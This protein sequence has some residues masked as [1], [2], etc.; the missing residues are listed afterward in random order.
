MNKYYQKCTEKFQRIYS[1]VAHII[2]ISSI[3]Y[4]FHF[5]RNNFFRNSILRFIHSVFLSSTCVQSM[6]GRCLMFSFFPMNRLF[7][8]N[9]ESKDSKRLD[10]LPLLSKDTK[11]L[12]LMFENTPWKES[13]TTKLESWN[14][15]SHSLTLKLRLL[16][17]VTFLNISAYICCIYNLIRLCLNQRIIWQQ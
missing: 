2:S 3:T 12:W 17:A 4:Y 15:A 9:L 13:V 6:G 10:P 8:S 7:K 5:A 14:S 1:M 16:P 11:S